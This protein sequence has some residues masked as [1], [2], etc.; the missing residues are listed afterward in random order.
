MGARAGLMAVG[1]EDGGVRVVRLTEA[2]DGPVGGVEGPPVGRTGGSGWTGGSGG[3]KVVALVGEIVTV[4]ASSK[5]PVTAL[6]FS[7]DGQGPAR[8][9]RHVIPCIVPPAESSITEYTGACMYRCSPHHQPHS[10]AVL[11]TS[12]QVHRYT[13][14][15][16]SGYCVSDPSDGRWLAAGSHDR[17]VAVHEMKRPPTRPPV[18]WTGEEIRWTVPRRVRCRGHSSTAGPHTSS[19]FSSSQVVLSLKPSKV[20]PASL[21]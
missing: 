12:L 5:T 20:H 8:A 2:L 4:A 10:V 11:V 6:S 1:M 17:C 16:Q 9:A 3:S 19:P 21:S 7:P 15:K 14:S 18:G 13:F